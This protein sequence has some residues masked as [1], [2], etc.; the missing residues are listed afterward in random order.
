MVITLELTEKE[1]AMIS[2]LLINRM[3]R[4]SKMLAVFKPIGGFQGLLEEVEEHKNIYFKLLDLRFPGVAGE[5]KKRLD[6]KLKALKAGKPPV[7]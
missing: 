7:V 1:A 2:W 4:D 3:Q 6:A 5:E